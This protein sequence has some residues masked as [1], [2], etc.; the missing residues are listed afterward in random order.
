MISKIF[1]WSIKSI[2]DLSKLEGIYNLQGIYWP[3]ADGVYGVG[4]KVSSLVFKSLR[5]FWV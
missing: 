5:L 3:G 2:R 1:S 4:F